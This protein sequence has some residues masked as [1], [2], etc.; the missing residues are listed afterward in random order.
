MFWDKPLDNAISHLKGRVHAPLR[1]V[2]WDGREVSF[3]DTPKVT[4]R[5][6]GLRG[7]SALSRPNLLS[8][9]E[10]YIEG[11]AD[12]EGDVREAIRGAEAI[13]RAIP[14]ALFQSQGPTNGRHSKRGDRE[15]IQHHYDV[16]NEFYALWLDPRMVYSCAYFR[17]E[18]DSLEQAQLQKLDHICTKL[19]LQ[20]G[21]RFLDIG[22]GWGALVM[23]AAEKYG[24]QATGVTLSENQFHLANRWI[25]ERG[26][27]DRCRVIMQDYRDIPGE[28][29]YDKIA[30]VGMFE[31]VGLRNLPLYFGTVRRLLKEKGVFLNHGI[32]S[33]DPRNRAVGFGAGEFIH[34]YVFPRGELPHLH[35]AIHDMADQDF[36]VHDVEGLRP[37]YART[38]GFWSANYE[39]H[40]AQ[41]TAASSER[42]ARI[43]R[44]YLAGCAH[45]F[46]EG[47]ISIYQVLATKQSKPGRAAMPL[48]R[49]YMYR[50]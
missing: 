13:S 43:W 12:V 33:M 21:E 27:E 34:R 20:P 5:L 14:K 1:L 2:L 8:L 10:A 37:H 6:K 31:H 38:L 16:S 50:A 30:S 22:C 28:G 24:V 29:V 7:A 35:L 39:R 15:A 36:E 9:A 45:A 3:S 19:R 11:E 44:L 47:W 42:I 41:A 25:R 17:T 4:V 49:D 32:T 40:L 48:T 23:H 46:E 18:D 26:L